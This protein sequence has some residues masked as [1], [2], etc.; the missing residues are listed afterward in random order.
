ME[1]SVILIPV[2][3]ADP[4]VR[5]WREKYDA[6][7]L[8]GIPAHITLLF[9]FQP[10]NEINTQTIEKLKQVFVN[11][12]QF[13]FFLEKINTFPFVIFLEPS[14]RSMFIILT[15]EII[16]AF[17]KY[18]QYG[19]KFRSITPHLT[20]GQLSSEQKI[21]SIKKRIVKDIQNK[22]PIKSKAEEAW[23]MIKNNTE[24][25][26]KHRFPFSSR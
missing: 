2:Q 21:D 25:S 23:L 4:I 14:A 15:K 7:A 18:P 11:V 24:W 19:G 12:K 16:R 1:E 8:H 26:L 13:A 6:V 20:V 22:L 10:P 9:P 3:R 17:P 5:K